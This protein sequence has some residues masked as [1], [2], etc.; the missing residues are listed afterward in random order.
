MNAQAQGI[1]GA[2]SGRWHVPAMLALVLIATSFYSYLL[3]HTLLELLTVLVAMAAFV[4]TWHTFPASRNHY[5][6]LLGC[7]YFWVGALDLVHT[8]AYR[9]MNILPS[10]TTSN[11][12]TQLWIAARYSEAL[13]LLAAP[14]VIARPLHRSLS[15]AL[16]AAVAIALF[17]LIMSGNFPDCFVEGKGLTPFKIYS[18]YLIIA[19]LFGAMAQLWQR[20]A[21]LD[22]RIVAGILLANAFTVG[23]ELCFTQYASVFGPANLLGHIFK[24]FGFW[25]I[26]SVLV[27]FAFR[28]PQQAPAPD[29]PPYRPAPRAF[30]PLASAAV[31]VPL[32]IFCAVAWQG[33][34]Q[35]MR[36]T[37]V[38]AQRSAEIFYR[39]ARNVFQ[40]HELIAERVSEHLR[41]MSWDEIEQSNGIRGY[42]KQITV[43]FPQAQ[44]IW[45]ADGSGRIRNASEPLPASP[46]SVADRDYF[47]ALRARDRG[48]TIGQLVQGRVI[49]GW[50]FSTARRRESASGAFDG[51]VIVTIYENYFSDFWNRSAA[52][53][54]TVVALVRGDGQFLARAPRIEPNA[55]AIPADAPLFQYPHTVE[56]GA[57]RTRS[58]TDGVDRF[59]VFRRLPRYDVLLLYGNSI[60]AALASWRAEM[61]VYAALFGSAALALLMLALATLRTQ[62]Q[63]EMQ[64]RNAILEA[65]VR[66]RTAELRESEAR[67]RAIASNSPDHL[68]VQD[69]ELRYVYVMNPQLGLTEA[70][71]L[72]KT[73]RDF[74]SAEDAGKL[75]A[76]KRRV[77]KDAKPV[78]VQTFLRDRSGDLQWFEGTYVPRLGEDGQPDGLIG[79]FRNVTERKKTEAEIQRRTA[80]LD[81]ANKD[82]ESFSYSVSHDLRAPL[83]SI[84]GF[85]RMLEEDYSAKIDDEGK[86]ALHRVRSAAQRMGELIDDL[87]KLSRLSRS[88]MYAEPV[89]LSAL[90]R[91]VAEDLK[92]SDPGRNVIFDIPPRLEAHGDRRLLTVLLENLL[93]NAWK[94]TGRHAHARIELGALQKDGKPV[95]FVR[96]DGAGFDMTYVATL[97]APFQRLHL[98]ADFPGTGIGLATVRRIVQRHGGRVWAEAAVEQG[99]TFYFTLEP[100]STVAAAT[101]AQHI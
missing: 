55:L 83:R 27:E 80:E 58:R 41:A 98:A 39:H 94:F 79:Y 92:A 23:A 45:L 18:E 101:A 19:I 89:D 69:K 62:R 42:L 8:L 71:M 9:G 2:I 10:V 66:E 64:E 35:T 37:Q 38:D 20:R 61:A 72:G 11:E 50:N 76:V 95:Y 96:D 47:N 74:L 32:L 12:P 77:L 28:H 4:V 7:G 84:D 33:Y 54:G 6:L 100:E 82:L 85:A 17:S 78:Q 73:D 1:R 30:W 59:Y 34:Q 3:F 57:Y 46:L 25:M 68:I 67:F 70:D 53:P 29:A 26:Y 75:E 86:D 51:A 93:G 88:D 22:P 43:D 16:P 14:L 99:A 91:S 31:L 44:A 48:T 5:L 40:T 49:K 13:L 21:A 63:A 81:A 60:D 90:A 52:E 65:H 15:F 36:E 56:Q 24:L 97:F 87:L